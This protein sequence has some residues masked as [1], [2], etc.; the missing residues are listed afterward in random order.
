MCIDQNYKIIVIGR[1][2][3]ITV[4]SYKNSD[5]NSTILHSIDVTGYGGWYEYKLFFDQIYFRVLIV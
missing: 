2:D 3:F 1:H 4:Y 5:F